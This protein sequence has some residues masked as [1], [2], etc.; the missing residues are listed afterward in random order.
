MKVIANR[1]LQSVLKAAGVCLCQWRERERG[2]VQPA[3]NWV[4]KCGCGARCYLFLHENVT[5][6]KDD[7][8]D[9]D[10]DSPLLRN[11]ALLAQVRKSSLKLLSS[12]PLSDCLEVS[13]CHPTPTHPTPPHPAP[14]S[15]SRERAAH[16]GG[17]VSAPNQKKFVIEKFWTRAGKLE[18]T[19]WSNVF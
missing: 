6:S 16:W 7:D 4:W 18:M 9:D 10:D 2:S 14:G 12:T 11:A 13:R 8:D 15:L 17:N 5:C 19:F 3:V 1:G